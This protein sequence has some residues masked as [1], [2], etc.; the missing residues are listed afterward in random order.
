MLVKMAGLISRRRFTQNSVHVG[1]PLKSRAKKREFKGT[2]RPEIYPISPL[3][4]LCWPPH[5]EYRRWRFRIGS[6]QWSAIAEREQIQNVKDALRLVK[7][8]VSNE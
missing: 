4:D 6:W 7:N 1:V 3:L 5:I 8:K 2:E